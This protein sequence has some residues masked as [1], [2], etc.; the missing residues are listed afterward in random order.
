MM[1]ARFLK[2]YP[3]PSTTPEEFRSEYYILVLLT[4]PLVLR[5][6]LTI[7]MESLACHVVESQ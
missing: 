7:S 6:D 3:D 4:C 5:S 2:C 1:F